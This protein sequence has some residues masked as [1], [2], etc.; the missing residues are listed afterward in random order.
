[1]ILHTI[2]AGQGPPVVLLHGLFGSARNLGAV[3]RALAPRFRVLA[4]DLR[5]HGASPHAE[6]MDYR[7]MAADVLETLDQRAALP[8]ALV[9]HSMGGKAAMMAALL[10]PEQVAR[11][12]VGDIA[13]VAYQHHNAEIADALAALTLSPGLTRAA[14]DAALAEAVPD[15]GLRAFLLQNLVPGAHPAWRIGLREI[16]SDMRAIEGWEAQADTTYRGPTLFVAGAASDYVRPEHRP[17]IRALFPAARFVTLKRAGHW[18][19]ADNPAG[20]VAV[21]EAFLSDWKGR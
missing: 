7:A 10:H 5:N 1:V 8:A 17:A 18:L 12:V 2:E 15:P 21:I 4:M 16:A 13:P 3:Q 6:A 19:H 20:F 11:L 9:G 14:A